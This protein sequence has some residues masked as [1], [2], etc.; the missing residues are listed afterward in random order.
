MYARSSIIRLVRTAAEQKTLAGTSE[1]LRVVTEEMD[2]WCSLV[3]VAAPGSDLEAGS[4][5]LFVLAYWVPNPEIRVW[6]ELPFASMTG[7]VLRS[8][9]PERVSLDDPRLMS[10]VPQFVD[11]Y[12]S[13]HFCL[14]PMKLSDGTSAVLEVYRQADQPFSEE[15]MG[16]AEQLAAMLPALLASLTDRVGFALVEDVSRA[17]RKADESKTP[18]SAACQAI[19]DEIFDAFPSLEVSMFLESTNEEEGVFRLAAHRKV[20]EGQWT[21]RAEYGKGFG[22][23][24]WVLENGRTV[25]IADLARYDADYKWISSQYPGLQWKDSLRIRDRARDYFGID[26]PESSPPLSWICAP[27]RCDT[28]IFGVIRCAGATRPPFH[29]DEWQAK[30]LENVGERVGA[31]WHNH[32][33]HSAK[34]QEV[35]AWEALMHGFDGLNRFVRRQFDSH[36]S[37]ETTFFREAMRLAHQVIPNTDNSEV[38]LREVSQWRT[39]ATYGRDWDQY[40]K[41]KTATYPI[42]TTARNAPDATGV[43][44]FDDVAQAPSSYGIFPDTRKLIVAP[45]EEGNDVHGEL[46]IRS[47]SPRRFPQNVKLIAGLLGQQLGLYHSLARQ[48]ALLQAVERKN[49]DLINTQA[50]TIGDVHHQVKSPII[51][52]YRTAQNM[53]ARPALTTPVR[54]DL[55][56]L[57]GMCSTVNRVVRNMGMFADLSNEKPIRLNRTLLMRTRLT[58]MLADACADHQS[59]TDPERG[60]RFHLDEK[61]LQELADKDMIGKLVES[62][63]ALLEQCVN[64]LLDNAAKYSYDKTTVTVTGGVQSKGTEFY[65]AVLNEGFEV[66][67]EDVPKLK[68]R[69][70]RSDKAISA[71]GEG[72]GIGLWIVDE[73]MR[74]HGGNLAITATQNG[75]TEVRLVF[76]VVKGIENLSDAAQHSAGRR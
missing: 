27:L 12:R 5:R 14:A 1:M 41:A 19:V 49:R 53:L 29:F 65:I 4:G 28:K 40:P 64:N 8:G 24:G 51:S 26:D 32:L 71:T 34:E 23:T 17:R 35:R 74:A 36:K 20:W 10:P 73:I 70:Y 66:R 16:R 15:E 7:Q 37:D 43:R 60:I 55:E 61:G 9:R 2:G 72:S 22:A 54:A 33:R 76:P 46:C 47:N 69:G 48:I 45:I 63:S 62:D 39:V 67:P 59:L 56:R 6:H 44:I 30:V 50:K 13:R 3:W 25:Q 38:R 75:I 57:R 42:G 11:R 21:E 18:Y 31:W 68:V 52:A 58:R